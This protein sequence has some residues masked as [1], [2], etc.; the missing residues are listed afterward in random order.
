MSDSVSCPACVSVV[1][2]AYKARN[3]L[4]D[5]LASV[6][7]QQHPALEIVVI[8][9]AS[10]EPI[11]DIIKAF[12]NELPSTTTLRVL[13]H[14]ENQGLGAARNTGIHAARGEYVAF[15]DHDD[16]WDPS[17]LVDLVGLL[18]TTGAGLAYCT[19]REFSENPRESTSLWGPPDGTNE[20]NFDLRL[21]QNSFIT[22]SSVVVRKSILVVMG[23][24][25]T[26]PKLHMCEDMDLWLRLRKAG[27]P[28]IHSSLQT[29]Y[30]RKHAEAATSRPCY[31]AF[32]A[33][34]V[35]ELHFASSGGSWWRKRMILAKAWWYAHRVF[36][37]IERI[38]RWDLLGK[39]FV[40]SLPVPWVLPGAAHKLLHN[41]Y[42]NR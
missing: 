11:D 36:L 6:A 7:A 31:M 34:Y 3:Y 35:R 24:F 32:Q 27:I 4:A 38:N 42:H 20:H 10:P 22:P 40:A 33:A 12:Q 28:M 16:L 14:E 21:Y 26:D 15:L 39:A 9:D 13:R 1:I 2:P 17:H 29:V 25:S 8:D 37:R 30:Y 18:R 41:I 5:A 19:V 23:G